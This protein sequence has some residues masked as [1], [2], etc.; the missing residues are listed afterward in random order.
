M[1]RRAFVL[2]LALWAALP[3]CKSRP[4]DE[5]PD[6][7]VRELVERLRRLDGNP[8]N[9]KAVFQLLSKKTRENLEARADRYSAASGKH[10]E[11][12]MM[13]APQ[14]FIERFSAQSYVTE[15]K[16][17][18]AIVRAHGVVDAEVS[19]IHCVYEDGGW[20]VDVELPP[21]SPVVVRPRE[22]PFNQ[23]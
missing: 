5:T 11:P 9:A 4:P 1:K 17:G 14:S 3:S 21:L 8:K 7:A 13:I 15:T 10:I 6:G 18:Y 16:D 20:R 19:E 12:E 22:E 2:A 23:R